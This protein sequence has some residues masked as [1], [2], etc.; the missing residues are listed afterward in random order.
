[1]NIT[2]SPITLITWE[3]RYGWPKPVR[4]EGGHHRF[5]A[6]QVAQ[7]RA[8]DQLRRSMKISEAIALLR[9]RLSN[10]LS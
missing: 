4:T 10:S 8:V 1:M 6:Q 5:T 7:L 2:V 3:Q 9:S